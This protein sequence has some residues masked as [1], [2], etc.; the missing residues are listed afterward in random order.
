MAAEHL[1]GTLRVFAFMDG[2]L[3]TTDSRAV[4]TRSMPCSFRYQTHCWPITD[5]SLDSEAGM[6]GEMPSHPVAYFLNSLYARIVCD[7][8]GPAVGP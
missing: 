7:M 3:S 5:N 1:L 8:V 4:Y 6:L 2:V